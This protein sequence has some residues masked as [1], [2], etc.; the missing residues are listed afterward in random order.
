MVVHHPILTLKLLV[1][2]A[3]C[4]TLTLIRINSHKEHTSAFL[5]VMSQQ[6]GYKVYDLI[7]HQ[8]LISRDVKFYE[9]TFPFHSQSNTTQINV[10]PLPIFPDE[11]VPPETTLPHTPLTQLDVTTATRTDISPTLPLPLPTATSSPSLNTSG[12]VPS[13]PDHSNSSNIIPTA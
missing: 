12:S 9:D 8:I 2:Y 11:Q 4:Q 5:L 6:K 13:P 1:V 3:M 7:N 10:L